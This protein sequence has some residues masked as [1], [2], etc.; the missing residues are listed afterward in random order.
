MNSACVLARLGVSSCG[1]GDTFLL[2]GGEYDGDWTGSRFRRALL[3]PHAC[4]LDMDT[5][6]CM[7]AALYLCRLHERSND[8]VSPGESV[9]S[10]Q[11]LFILIIN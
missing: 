6:R 5:D 10:P 2:M 11:N 8:F 4:A 3:P 7:S 1:T 9:R